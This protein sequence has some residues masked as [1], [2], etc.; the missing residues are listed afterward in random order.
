ML[1]RHPEEVV[2]RLLKHLC[3]TRSAIAMA[4]YD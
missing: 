2:K 3:L 4:G 1:R